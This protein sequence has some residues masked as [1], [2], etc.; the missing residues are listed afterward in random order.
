MVRLLLGTPTLFLDPAILG[1]LL[2]FPTGDISLE[3]ASL[4][5]EGIGGRPDDTGGLDAPMVD[6]AQM[7]AK[8][9]AG[10][11]EECPRWNEFRQRADRVRD[12]V[13]L[14]V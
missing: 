14:P 4:G 1:S 6:V 3:V 12:P 11:C 9:I 7:I 10:G 2:V 13:S 5:A 8:T